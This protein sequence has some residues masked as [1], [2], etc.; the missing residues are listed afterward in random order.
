MCQIF[1][2]LK[3]T[4]TMFNTYRHCSVFSVSMYE[5]EHELATRYL[6]SYPSSLSGWSL[7]SGQT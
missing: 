6:P 4:N 5:S 3:F 2:D 1:L 7:D